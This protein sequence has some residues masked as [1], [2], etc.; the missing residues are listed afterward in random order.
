[1]TI[2][3]YWDGENFLT[4][5]KDKNLIRYYLGDVL[6]RKDGPAVFFQSMCD[7]IFIEV[8][9]HKGKP[10]RENGPAEIWYYKYNNIYNEIYHFNGIRI[11][12]EDL[13]FCFPIDDEKKKLYMRLKYGDNNE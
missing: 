6:H 1:M 10:H 8:Y 3:H 12:S 5:D 11:N 7:S 13:P 2:E 9:Y 4:I